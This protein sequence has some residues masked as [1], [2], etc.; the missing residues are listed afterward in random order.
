MFFWYQQMDC[1]EMASVDQS[2]LCWGKP[3]LRKVLTSGKYHLEPFFELTAKRSL[4][5]ICWTA[6][7]FIEATALL[8]ESFFKYLMYLRKESDR[9]PYS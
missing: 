6:K 7:G 2:E 8:I 9:L 1:S 5:G 4:V 3:V